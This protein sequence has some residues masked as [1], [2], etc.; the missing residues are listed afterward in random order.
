[1]N[2]VCSQAARAASRI[3]YPEQA[4]PLSLQLN[5]G[6]LLAPS[7]HSISHNVLKLFSGDAESFV[8]ACEDIFPVRVAGAHSHLEKTVVVGWIGDG[9]L[10]GTL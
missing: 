7:Y 1:M 8:V 3:S 2:E 10:N 6:A 9:V 4:Y 5:Q